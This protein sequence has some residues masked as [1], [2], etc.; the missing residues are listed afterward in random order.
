MNSYRY[1]IKFSLDEAMYAEAM[2]WISVNTEAIK[3]YNNRIVKSLYFDDSNYSSVRDNIIGLS[4]RVKYRL[5]WYVNNNAKILPCPKFETKI[6]TGRLGRKE[7]L[8]LLSL[9]EGFESLPLK[10][11][12]LDLR[13][14]LLNSN[15]IL[16]D[17]LVPSLAV[18]YLR[19][20]YEDHVGLRIT[21]DKNI[22]FSFVDGINTK[23]CDCPKTKHYRY[24]MELK[25]NPGIKDHV[26][27][28]IG[29]LNMTPTRHSK[30]LVGLAKFGNILYI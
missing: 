4:D 10:E 17:Y 2:S 24:I 13:K 14:L 6:K 23:L 21:I 11:I 19:E 20:Y 26:S 3:K 5:R 25:F 22:E 1:E 8:D 18:T 16:E 7:T 30:Y 28:L 15:Y 29:E 12:E 9:T 27:K